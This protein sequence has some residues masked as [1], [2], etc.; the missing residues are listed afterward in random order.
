MKTIN[1]LFSLA[2]LLTLLLAVTPIQPAYAAGILYAKIS[3]TGT[4]NCSS[5]GNACT[6][7]T[8]LA[9]AVGGNE[10]WVM[11]GTHKPTT[12]ADRSATFQLKSGVAVYGGFAG[13]E[14]ARG[15]RNIT[16]NITILSGNIGAAGNSDNSYHVVSGADGA[17]LDGFTVQDGFADGASPAWNGGGMYNN[18]N[19]PTLANIIFTNNTATN[20]GG[21][22]YN[23][24]S[25]PT[26]TNVTFSGNTAVD[27]GGMYNNTSDPTLSNVTFNGNKATNNGGGMLNGG[28]NGSTPTLTNVTFIN[29]TTT[30]SGGGMYNY[31]SSP[32]LADITFSGNSARQGGGLYNYVGSPQITDSTFSGNS[33]TD[34]GGGMD[35]YEGSAPTLTNVTFTDNTATTG[36]GGGMYNYKSSPIL[37]GVTFS[38]NS[39]SSGGGMSNYT[40]S[41]PKLARVTFNNNTASSG[42][43]GMQNN[44]DS[45][46]TLTNTTFSNNNAE[47]GAG[48]RNLANSNPRLTNVTFNENVATSWGGGM[49]NVSSSPTLTNITFS[50]N[51]ASTGAGMDNYTGSNPIL[52]NIT[53]NGNTA[54]SRSGGMENNAGSSPT[55]RN[56]V[57]WGN[58]G[59]KAQIYNADGGSV[60]VVEDSV[61]QGGYAGGTNIINANPMLGTLD[62]YGGVTK[63]ISLLAGSSAIDKGNDTTCPNTDQRGKTRPQGAHCDIGA[64]EAEGTV[65]LTSTFRSTGTYDGWIL[66]ST[67]NST[68]GGT[69]DKTAIT[70]RLGDNAQDKQF[71]AILHFNTSNLPD[72]ATITKVTLKIKQQGLAGTNPF[73]IFGGLRVDVQKPFFGTTTELVANDFQ[74]AAG[75]SA[76]AT[77]GTTPV[78]NWYSAVLNA[79]GRTYINRAGITQF[80]LR[81][82]TGDNDNNTADFMSFFSGNTTTAGDR[83]TLIIQYYVP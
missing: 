46:P 63:T 80:R 60:P 59:P 67:E 35:N 25:S 39:A 10:I 71:R 81:F 38:G 62:N 42:G 12:D 3:N 79:A 15:Q 78:S 50:G 75:K 13:T 51:S 20:N 52:T 8:A 22:M 82:V 83:P 19:S 70:F 41:S 47:T 1:R 29:N 57:F 4:G 32:V 49:Y 66:E 74:A 76:V 72:T 16:A 18:S 68:A 7:Q 58:P 43:G 17:T 34:G 61:V 24:S 45:N 9:S 33:A 53:F 44:T 73:G 27:G 77:F 48:M 31:L 36:W 65:T 2:S 40:S 55:I 28:V 23:I 69:L 6:L 5:W 64:Y 21:G 26:L 30:Y 37:T 56:T 54:S 11:K 14:T